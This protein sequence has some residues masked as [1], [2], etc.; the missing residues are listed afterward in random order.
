MTEYFSHFFEGVGAGDGGGGGSS[1][2]FGA[3]PTSK[4]VLENIPKV[5]VQ[6]EDLLDPANI[7]CAI[8]LET[9]EL[10]SIVNR[11]PCGH[12]FHCSCVGAWLEKH[13]TCP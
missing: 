5:A 10:N 3:P 4:S 7:E 13:C 1:S 8:C 6:A 9:N 11:L 12:L 2:E